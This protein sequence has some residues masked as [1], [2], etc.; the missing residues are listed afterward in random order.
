MALVL[1]HR[2]IPMGT[3]RKSYHIPVQKAVLICHLV[4]APRNLILSHDVTSFIVGPHGHH[5]NLEYELQ[6]G[7][8]D[9]T[10]HLP[11]ACL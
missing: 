1:W 9:C 2:A 6:M 11:D 10:H 4:E 3:P 7:F 5:H 8:D